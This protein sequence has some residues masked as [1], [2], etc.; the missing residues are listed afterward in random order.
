MKCA[1]AVCV[2]DLNALAELKGLI[3]GESRCTMSMSPQLLAEEKAFSSRFAE[4]RDRAEADAREKESRS[5]ALARALEEMQQSREELEKVNKALRAEADDLI[6]SKDD[7]G[8]S[9]SQHV[10]SVELV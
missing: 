7:V 3:A 9:V 1:D 8:K 4:E 10:Y 5:L 6:S 2:K